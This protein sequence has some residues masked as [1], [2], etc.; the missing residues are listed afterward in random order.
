MESL[1]Y[2]VATIY[3][4]IFYNAFALLYGG[5]TRGKRGL[6]DITVAGV[7]VGFDYGI[8]YYSGKS[9]VGVCGDSPYAGRESTWGENDYHLD[10]LSKPAVYIP[11]VL[12]ISEQRLI[13]HPEQPLHHPRHHHRNGKRKNCE[14]LKNVVSDEDA[15]FRNDRGNRD[16]SIDPADRFRPVDRNRNDRVNRDRSFEPI[17]RIS[18]DDPYN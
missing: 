1:K 4:R 12:A 9:S 7:E 15:L 13:V 6:P 2:Y 8:S 10:W 11:E 3:S 14:C 17:D 18:F 16:R 5:W